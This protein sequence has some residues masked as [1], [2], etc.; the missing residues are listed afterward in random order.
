MAPFPAWGSMP[1]PSWLPT[2]RAELR[3]ARDARLMQYREFGQRY[4]WRV[5]GVHEDMSYR[6]PIEP[7]IGAMSARAE[8][9]LTGIWGDWSALVASVRVKAE[10]RTEKAPKP[11]DAIVQLTMLETGPDPRQ[12]VARWTASGPHLVTLTASAERDRTKI[13]NF[14]MHAAAEGVLQVGDAL[15]VDE[16]EMLH[17][18]IL[19]ER[20][21]DVDLRGPLGVLARLTELLS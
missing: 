3:R 20:S 7:L 11:R 17:A 19:S 8:L 9:A 21:H 16:V 10:R 12:F 14:M 4:D 15:A 5:V 2:T 1:R 6:Y 13:V 18:R